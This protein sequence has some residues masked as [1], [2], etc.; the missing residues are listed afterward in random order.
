MEGSAIKQATRASHMNALYEKFKESAISV[1][2]IVVIVTLL[3]LLFTPMSSGLLLAFLVGTVMIIAGMGLFTLGA[4]TSMTVIG[5]RIGATLTKS[6]KLWLILLVSFVLGVAVT[7]SEPDLQVLVDTVPHIDTMVLIL[8]VGVG[9]GFFLM[10]C[11]LRIFLGIKL[12]W[13]L[14]FFYALMLVLAIDAEKC[15]RD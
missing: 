13:L 10:I 3:C 4:E 5:N 11:M 7:V 8:T 14:I 6:K 9:V 1:L 2:P 12:R 15:S